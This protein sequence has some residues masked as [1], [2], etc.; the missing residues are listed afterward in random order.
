MSTET[1]AKP[2]SESGR[3]LEE[4]RLAL[5][6]KIA[7]LVGSEASRPTAIPGLTLFRE[8]APTTPWSGIYE[9]NVGVIVQGRKRVEFGRST[10]F[11]D[12]AHFL[13][14]SVELPV[15]SQV[16]EASREVPYLCLRLD[17]QIP[18]V[19]ELLV[20]EE[21]RVA[22]PPSHDV[23]MTTAKTTVDFLDS[24]S[25]LLDLV[26]NPK[27]IPFLSPHIQREIIYRILRSA[28]G[29]RLREIATQDDHNH[30]T[31]KAIAWIKAN[32]TRPLRV[33]DLAG[34]AGMA[35]STL[36]QHFRALTAMTPIQ[37]QKQL[38]LNVAR[39]R[40]LMNGIDAASAAFE[41][42]YES[43]SQFSREYSRFFGQPP[44][45]DIRA[46]RSSNAVLKHTV[47]GTRYD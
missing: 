5:V 43:A 32:Y 9:P 17:L 45:R 3:R 22:D 6:R 13:L 15:V 25:R 36:H 18:V 21:I 2:A 34:I 39:Q 41:V 47:H 44:M 30:R 31:A 1:Q 27:D 19:Q 42:G 8:I 11:Y 4:Q 20:R 10:F 33:E 12:A 7:Q 38:R 37:Y 46:L 26:N 23:A 14:T 40:M 29:Q 28:E 35:V 16:V 24:F